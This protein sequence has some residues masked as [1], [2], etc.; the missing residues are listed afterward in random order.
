MAVFFRSGEAVVEMRE[1]SADDPKP[2]LMHVRIYAGCLLLI[3]WYDYAIQLI[4]GEKS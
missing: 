2:P 4:S 1:K 3:T